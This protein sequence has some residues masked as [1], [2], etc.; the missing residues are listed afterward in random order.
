MRF[1]AHHHVWDLAVRDQPWTSELPTLR[2]SFVF[3]E[4][5]PSLRAHHVDATVLVQ[6]VTVAEETPEFLLLADET[7]QIGG[8]VGWVDLTLPDVTDQ[9][10]ALREGPGGRFLV[11]LRHQVQGEPDPDWLCREDVRKG[12]A[13][14]EA[15]GLAFDLLVLPTQLPAAVDTVRALPGL[16]FVLDHAGKPPIASGETEPWGTRIAELAGLANCAIKLSGLVTEARPDWTTEDLAPY[17]SHVL[18]TF[19]PDRTMFGSDWP[20]CLLAATYDEVIRASEHLTSALSADEQADVF[21]GT[22]ERFYGLT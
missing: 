4:L 7:P 22:A 16:S 2:R 12:L 8:V 17:A 19:G 21:G 6:T 15:A 11:G 18:E 20:V 1:D 14:V 13:A 5:V 3:D 10:A 9:L